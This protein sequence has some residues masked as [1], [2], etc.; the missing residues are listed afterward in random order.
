MTT[1]ALFI[2]ALSMSAP[3]N[4]IAVDG[5]VTYEVDGMITVVKRF[6]QIPERATVTTGANSSLSLRFKSGSMIRLAGKTQIEISELVHGQTAGRRKEKVKLITGKMWA[7][8]MKLL[9][10]DSHF[11]ITTQHAA[12]GV[13]G[14][15]FWTE[16]STK[17]TTFVI[18]HGAI[19]VTQANGGEQLLSGRGAS[20]SL[21]NDGTSTTRTLPAQAI[22]NL[23]YAINGSASSMVQGFRDIRSGSWVEQRARAASRNSLQSPDQFTESD[24]EN[25]RSGDTRRGNVMESRAIVNVELEFPNTE[26]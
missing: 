6:D 10:R 16:T 5:T 17:S 25:Q 14:T 24:L 19:A 22:A 13:R 11:E 20:A 7:R 2:T 21:G 26:R 3:A 12:A 4:A 15:A 9:G 23:R 1:L 8:I 18:D